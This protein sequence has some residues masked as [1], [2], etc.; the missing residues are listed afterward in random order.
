[1]CLVR[2]SLNESPKLLQSVSLPEQGVGGKG[3]WPIV[4]L[5]PDGVVLALSTRTSLYLYLTLSGELVESLVDVHRD[6]ISALCW[7]PSSRYVASGG[8]GDRH[9]R[10]WH[11]TPGLRALKEDL[12]KRIG[13]ASAN[14]SFKVS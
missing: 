6:T 3:A 8:G 9:V 4:A 14:E 5:S 13:K 11:N 7:D 1:M 2:Y 12:E 10:V